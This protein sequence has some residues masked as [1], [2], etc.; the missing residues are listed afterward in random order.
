MALLYPDLETILTHK[1]KPELGE[2]HLLKFLIDNLDASFEIFF[3]PMLNGDRPDIVIL[4]KGF[5]VLII[6]VKDY[7]LLKYRLDERKNWIVNYNGARIKSPINQVLKYKENLFNLHIPQL[8]EKKIINFRLLN[9]VS[10]AI[11]F[12]NATETEIK[13]FLVTPYKHDENYNRFL[14]YNIDFIGSDNVNK[15]DFEKLLKKIKL[16]ASNTQALF[17]DELYDSFKRFLSPPKHLFEDGKDIPYSRRQIDIIYSSTREQRIKG[18]VG[19][20]KTTIMAAR[21]VQAYKRTKGTV[22]ILTYNITLKNYIHDKISQ[23]REEFP[24]ENF[25]ILNYHNFITTELNNLGIEFEFPENFKELSQEAKNIFF[26][27]NY[28]S[29]KQIFEENKERLVKYEAIFIDEIQDYKRSWMDIIKDYYLES[30]GEYVLFGDVKQ[31]IY[32]NQIV[33]KD[34]VTNVKGGPINL[35][36]CFRSDYK[37]KDL[38]IKYQE[39]IFKDKYELDDFNKIDSSLEIQ[40]EKNLQGYLNYMFLENTDS[41]SSLYNIIHENIINKNFVPNDITVLSHSISLLQKFDSYYRYSCNEKTNSMFETSEMVCNMALNDLK[42][43]N[44]NSLPSLIAGS[45]K[46]IQRYNDYDT[47]KAFAEISTLFTLYDLT[48]S[49]PDRFNPSLEWHCKKFKT[50]LKDFTDFIKNNQ[51]SYYDFKKYRDAILKKDSIKL[52]RNNKKLHFYMN[53]GTV[54]LSTIHSF[55]GWESDIVFL[56]VEKNH[57]NVEGT[58]DEILYTGLTRTKK[59]LVIINFGNMEYHE[60][61]KTMVATVN[62]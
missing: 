20:G 13:N 26:E 12:H 58:F 42:T 50:N 61:L 34:V 9:I 21:A 40:F 5:G 3:N 41:V 52:L 60:K 6:E 29:N 1:V 47:T 33:G 54:K 16:K 45:T 43:K 15:F 14:Q 28:Y 53:S 55:K 59:N 17:S 35:K 37:I 48:V 18:V 51:N 8:L 62:S 2:L 56:I 36:D 49:Y 32:N 4:R 24:W 39:T 57:A 31:N 44:S 25:V 19:S 22:L 27:D 11:Y 30:G 10:C 7:D 38:A 46:L 23:V